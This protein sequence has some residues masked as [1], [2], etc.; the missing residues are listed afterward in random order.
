MGGF[1]GTPFTRLQTWWRHMPEFTAWLTRCEELLESGLPAQDVLWY[2]GDAV[3]H[4]PDEDYPLPE[5]FRA[6]YLNH[7]VLTNRL[8]VKDG[9]FTIPE[10]T[11]WKVLWV[12]D[13]RH[14]L[15]A[16]RKRLAELSAAGGKVVFGGKDALVKALSPYAK[17][18]ATEPALGNR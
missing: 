8:A 3:D 15:P 9:R 17:D 1:N 6:D 5:G 11:S 13:E 12:P 14:M 18:V 7:D 2:L 4:K 10:G 16:T